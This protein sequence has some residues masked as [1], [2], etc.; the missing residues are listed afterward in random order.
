MHS[1]YAS[2]LFPSLA[3]SPHL[4]EVLDDDHIGVHVAVDAVLHAGILASSESALRQA[5]GDALLEADGVEL[6]DGCKRTLACEGTKDMHAPSQG[7]R[8]HAAMETW[9]YW[10]EPVPSGSRQR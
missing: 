5:A 4:F 7:W 6:V 8:T 10:T 1:H 9:T 3:S 2:L